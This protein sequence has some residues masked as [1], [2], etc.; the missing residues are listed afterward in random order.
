MGMRLVPCSFHDHVSVMADIITSS[1]TEDEDF[2][3]IFAENQSSNIKCP[4][5][6]C[7]SVIKYRKHFKD[8]YRSH[9]GEVGY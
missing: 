1:E 8:H 6:G 7:S 3:T 5:P 4:Y 9:T 2:I